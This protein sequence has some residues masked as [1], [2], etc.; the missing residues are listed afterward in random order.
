MMHGTSVKII[1]DIKPL[2]QIS[3]SLA[4]VVLKTGKSDEAIKSPKCFFFEYGVC[5]SDLK[6][7]W[8][9]AGG[10]RLH[11]QYHFGTI[12]VT[13]YLM[14]S[15]TQWRCLAGWYVEPIG[16]SYWQRNTTDK[17]SSIR[18]R[19]EVVWWCGCA[20]TVNARWQI[21]LRSPAVPDQKNYKVEAAKRGS[22]GRP[23][24]VW[25]SYLCHTAY[26][27]SQT[28]RQTDR[29]QTKMITKWLKESHGS[30]PGSFP[31]YGKRITTKAIV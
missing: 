11:L 27:K 25:V 16:S 1:P 12:R 24:S 23:R 30:I 10:P 6:S 2:F 5:D 21:L 26:Y 4:L 8:S 22:H 31:E 17:T 9:G 28:D 19:L 29:R 18:C 3:W 14:W 13:T 7:Y 15:W 20:V